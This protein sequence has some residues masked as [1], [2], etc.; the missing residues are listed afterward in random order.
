MGPH[1]C[2]YQLSNCTPIAYCQSRSGEFS[3]SV[4]FLYFSFSSFIPRWL[5][6]L[7]LS[8]LLLRRLFAVYFAVL[9]R[10]VFRMGKMISLTFTL[11]CQHCWLN[12]SN[13]LLLSGPRSSPCAAFVCLTGICPHNAFICI[14]WVH[15]KSISISSVIFLTL[16]DCLLNN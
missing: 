14:L 13:A 5:G 4:S 16:L 9:I 15:T 1:E 6:V 3:V 8:C 11:H 12:W 7:A 2:H 10:S